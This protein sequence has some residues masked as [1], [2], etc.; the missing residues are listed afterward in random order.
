MKTETVKKRLTWV[1]DRK[2]D[3]LIFSQLNIKKML[4]G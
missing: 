3:E 1:A 4:E 2:A